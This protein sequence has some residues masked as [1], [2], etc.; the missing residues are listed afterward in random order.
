MKIA[1]IETGGKQY[2]VK[3]GSKI[4][5][6]KVKGKENEKELDFSKVLLY[7]DDNE[8]LIGKPVL[9][10]I[11]VVGEIKRKKK[12]KTLIL[13]YKPKTR[14]RKKKGYKK[15]IWEVEIKRIEKVI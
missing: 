14:Y 13:K 8:L 9:E 2:L 1:V 11:K 4:K 5:I 7:A 6:E 3:E 10:N 15:E 12:V